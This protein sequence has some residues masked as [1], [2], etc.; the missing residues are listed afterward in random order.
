V[1]DDGYITEGARHNCL[2]LCTK[3]SRILTQT[4]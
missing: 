3:K 2:I 4:V 1:G